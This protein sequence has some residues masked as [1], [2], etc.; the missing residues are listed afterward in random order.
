MKRGTSR[1]LEGLCITTMVVAG[2]QFLATCARAGDGFLAGCETIRCKEIS[3]YK[4]CGDGTCVFYEM[5]D[6]LQCDH[7]FGICKDG[8]TQE[9]SSINTPQKSCGATWLS[10][11][12]ACPNPP[13]TYV[14][15][16]TGSH[17]LTP[18]SIG[19]NVKTCPPPHGGA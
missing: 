19:R 16:A 3:Y 6:C 7:S 8:T 11:V 13:G 18:T 14:V 17:T 2:V 10:D 15:E 4:I 9:C 12:C 5:P 1:A